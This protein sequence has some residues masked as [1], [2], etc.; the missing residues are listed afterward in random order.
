MYPKASWLRVGETHI[1]VSKGEAGFETDYRS[2]RP[3]ASS[4]GA[5]ITTPHHLV[6][7]NSI[8]SNH[9][10]HAE[11]G[12]VGI[13]ALRIVRLGVDGPKAF[14]RLI[15]AWSGAPELQPQVLIGASS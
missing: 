6:K 2:E 13:S 8:C 15:R 11:R 7:P 3:S 9:C 1:E 12:V 5:S 10:A 14:S 4:T